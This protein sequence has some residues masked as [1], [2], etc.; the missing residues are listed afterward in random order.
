MNDIGKLGFDNWF[1]ESSERSPS[2][3][4]QGKDKVDLSKTPEF[5][6]AREINVNKNSFVVPY[7]AGIIG[8]KNKTR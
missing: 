5:K 3:I 7:I 2:D 4:P 6:I 8:F 1:W